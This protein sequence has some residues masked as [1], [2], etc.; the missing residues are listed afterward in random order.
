M[1]HDVVIVNV[2]KTEGY[3]LPAA[4]AVL[5]GCCKYLGVSSVTIDLNLDFLH[6]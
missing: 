3:Y 5:K 2:P 1:N 6:N 4:P